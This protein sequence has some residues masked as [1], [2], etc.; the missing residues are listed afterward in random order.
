M[1]ER[2]IFVCIDRTGLF[3]STF[4]TNIFRT[5]TTGQIHLGEQYLTVPWY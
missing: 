1:I 5:R 3:L 4:Q 2:E